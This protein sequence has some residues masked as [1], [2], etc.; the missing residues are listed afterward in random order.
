MD[1]CRRCRTNRSS[2]WFGLSDSAKPNAFANPSRADGHDHDRNNRLCNERRHDVARA[3]TDTLENQRAAIMNKAKGVQISVREVSKKFDS[4]GADEGITA[5]S[6]VN[7]EIVR[8][9]FL[10]LLGPSGCGKSTL[11]NL[12]AGFLKPTS[13]TILHDGAAIAVPDRR[14]TALFH[15]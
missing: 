11:L 2:V 14:R 6:G 5:L 3:P 10:V 8:G 13:G 1:V 9:E 12:V 4:R 7:L 15:Y